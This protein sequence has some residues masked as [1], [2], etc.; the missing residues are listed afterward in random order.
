MRERA[1]I[2]VNLHQNLLHVKEPLLWKD[3]LVITI[4]KETQ[5]YLLILTKYEEITRNKSE[6]NSILQ[7][8]LSQ[9]LKNG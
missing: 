1:S 6:L 2:F 7:N 5:C 4:V 8:N 3:L 9:T